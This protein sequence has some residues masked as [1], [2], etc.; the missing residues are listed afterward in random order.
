M[1][2]T[3][4]GHARGIQ[5]LSANGT[6][7][8]GAASYA[9]N[10]IITAS[11][12]AIGQGAD[13]VNCS[14]GFDDTPLVLQAID[15]YVDYQVRFTT[16]TFAVSAGNNGGGTNDVSSPAVSFNCIAVGA[17]DDNNTPSWSDDIMASYSS[18]DD[19]TSTHGDREK[20]E[21]T[22]EGTE[23]DVVGPRLRVHL[24]VVS[25]TSF[26][27]P[28]VAGMCGA[29]MQMNSTLPGWPEA[30]K[31]IMMA[32]ATH[33][34]EGAS[35]LSDKDG[36]GAMNGLQAYRLIEQNKFQIG[37]FLP[38]SFSNNSYYTTNI[39]LQGGDK[40]R[41]CLVWD[42]LASGPAAYASDVL[43]ADL[44]IAILQGLGV[45]VGSGARELGLV[46]QPLRDRRVLPA[47]NRLVHG[48]RERLPLRRRERVLRTRLDA[49]RGRPGRALS[50]VAA[51]SRPPPMPSGPTIGN[52]V[53]LAGP[54]RLR[55]RRQDLLV[56]RERR[57]R[58]GRQ[59]GRLPALL[60]RLRL[61]DR[62]SGEPG[63]P[64]LHQLHRNLELL[65]DDVLAPLRHPR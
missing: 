33:N 25:G 40:A 46:G 38:T 28:G 5:I 24:L 49:G 18:F 37:T 56:G 12:W 36:A 6:T 7:A 42:S 22:A 20:P 51:R 45:T 54:D 34:V 43:N 47:G 26:A 19:P 15:H 61:R 13:V 53:L 4:P 50:P 64:V 63:K 41:V 65:R 30:M 9:T 35:R 32:A 55:Q 23:H 17:L 16:T 60:R 62:D 31:A 58:H 8:G 48:A 14:F 44:D 59:R 21:V 11:D 52:H 2:G 57:N 1:N 3:H 27:A 39:F 10:D 29:L